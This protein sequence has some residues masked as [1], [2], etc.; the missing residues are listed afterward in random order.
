M[1]FLKT[2]AAGG[3]TWAH[4]IRM[5]RQVLRIACVF[6]LLSGLGF[7]GLKIFQEPNKSYQSLWY[8]GKSKIV[9]LIYDK[10]SVSSQFWSQVSPHKYGDRSIEVQCKMLERICKKHLTDFASRFL[11]WLKQAGLLSSLIFVSFILFFLI[12]GLR[13]KRYKHITGGKI[14]SPTAIAIH[15]K[16]RGKA[17]PIKI[18]KLPLMR[19]TETQHIL[20]SGGTGSGKTNSFHHILPYIRKNNQ[21]AVIVDTTGTFVSKYY[22]E[23]RDILLNP[24]D[25]RGEPWHPWCECKNHFDYDALAQSF[26]PISHSDYENYW[27]GAARS[28][29]S[30]LLEKN[31]GTKK[32][33]QLTQSLLKSTLSDLHKELKDSRASSHLDPST[34]KTAGSIRSVAS[35]FLEC[36]DYLK[37]STEPFSIREWVQNDTKNG[38]WLFLVTTPS[39]RAVLVPLISAWY[40]I[41]MRSLM[42]MNTDLHRRL[43]FV[44]DELPT[45]QKLR[46]LETCLAEGR[47]F[48]A[49]ALLAM[50]SPAQ[51]EMI[52]GH[53]NARVIIGN[54]A[55]KVAF[56]EQDPTIAKQI[57]QIFGEKEIEEP[58]E[59]IS[60]GA[61]QMRDGVSISSIK[62]TKP[63]VSTS[64]IQSLNKNVAFVKLP[65]K[66]PI[67]K[68]KLKYLRPKTI[69]Q[70]FL[71]I[72]TLENMQ[73]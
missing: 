16:L 2:V 62:R 3:Q 28:V 53:H 61:H 59:G 57:S 36:L 55:T 73:S 44:S 67:T 30:A 24:F 54:C 14:A 4:R 20:I 5:I 65:G 38:A 12:K 42:Q 48:G 17:S 22:Q 6:S 34:D 37:D 64:D 51:L 8:Y 46:E 72:P 18:G 35:S 39:Q 29:F 58:Q 32:L 25:I 10:I 56:F 1:G 11:C 23:R 50:Q 33:S 26:I 47:K 31:Q 15:S 40:S 21:R 66:A 7:L 27:R 52:Y 60:Y 43:Y 69:A 19:G 45:L 71:P 63:V 9:G 70:A 49:C 13:T 41:A 68:L